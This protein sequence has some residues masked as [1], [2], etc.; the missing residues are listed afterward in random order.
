MAF[1]RLNYHL[2][3]ATHN[4][5]HFITEEIEQKL[6]PYIINKASKELDIYIQAINGWYDHMHIVASAPPKYSVSEIVKRLKGASSHH[7]N[8]HGAELPYKF[9]WQRGYGVLSLGEKQKAIAIDYVQRQKEHHKNQ[10]HNAWLERY[11]EEDEGPIDIKTVE[12]GILREERV[13]YELLGSPL[14]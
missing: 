11:T 9:A 13:P 7:L 2:V 10:T 12:I 8:H 6:F 5:E 3:W 14:I 4:R 1:W